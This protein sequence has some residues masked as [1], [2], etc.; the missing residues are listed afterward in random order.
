MARQIRRGDVYYITRSYQ[1]SGS[2]QYAG[3][4]AVVVSNDLNNAHC[5]VIDVVYLTTQPKADLP[6]HCMIRIS[7]RP[8]T[9]L[10]EHIHSVYTDRISEYITTLT[11]QEMREISDCVRIALDLQ[12]NNSNVVSTP[13]SDEYTVLKAERDF[14]EKRYNELLDHMYRMR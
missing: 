3:R 7:D 13:I 4:P 5:D 11:P 9:V 1:E 2:E 12:D 14:Y 8:S 10:C 6:T